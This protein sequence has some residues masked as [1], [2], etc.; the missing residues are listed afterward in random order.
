M[1]GCHHLVSG[2][3]HPQINGF[4]SAFPRG[5]KYTIGLEKYSE[6]EVDASQ[7]KDSRPI[8][9]ERYSRNKQNHNTPKSTGLSPSTVTV[10]QLQLNKDKIRLNVCPY[11]TT[12]PQRFPM[13]IQFVQ[14]NR[15]RSTLLTASQLFSLPPPTKMFQFSGFPI[16]KVDHHPKR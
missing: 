9:N 2:T 15:F 3:F 16:H 6:L 12:S 5:T 7:K 13:G 10:F 1:P 4:F 14:K 8:S 11:N